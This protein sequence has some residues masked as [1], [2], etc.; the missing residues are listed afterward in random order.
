MQR[1]VYFN[2][3]KTHLFWIRIRFFYVFEIV[4]DFLVDRL[5]ISQSNFFKRD[6]FKSFQTFFI[7]AILLLLFVLLFPLLET[8]FHLSEFQCP[9]I[10][11]CHFQYWWFP[12]HINLLN[13]FV[14]RSKE[15]VTFR[16]MFIY[17]KNTLL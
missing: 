2:E 16:F 8:I 13:N 7:F 10:H 11:C 9:K 4:L 15:M 12:K 3:V 1:F 14:V 5:K 6:G 17:W